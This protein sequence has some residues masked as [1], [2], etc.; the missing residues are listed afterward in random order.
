MDKAKVIQF[1]DTQA[2]QLPK[3]FRLNAEEVEIFRRGDEIVLRSCVTSL[4]LTGTIRHLRS[5]RGC[6]ILAPLP[7]QRDHLHPRL[8]GV[9][10][11]RH[12]RVV[13]PAAP[14]E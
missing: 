2:V 3:H 6:D 4:T 5:E 13:P 9:R 1:G 10:A 7:R 12:H 11:R 8:Q 14:S